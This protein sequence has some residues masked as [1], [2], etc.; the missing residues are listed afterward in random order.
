MS[1]LKPT[2]TTKSHKTKRNG[3]EHNDVTSRSAGLK[4]EGTHPEYDVEP[5]DEILDA[6]A[7][8]VSLEMLSCHHL[9]GFLVFNAS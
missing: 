7:H 8:F 3:R 5:E 2:D 4:T 9:D 6:A 1:T